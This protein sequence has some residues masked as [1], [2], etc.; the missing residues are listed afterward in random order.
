M[1]ALPNQENIVGRKFPLSLRLPVAF[2]DEGA[3]NKTS[4]ISTNNNSI[5]D[6][7]SSP[8]SRAETIQKLKQSNVSDED[9]YDI[10]IIGAG[11]TGAGVALDAASRGFKTACIDMEDISSG[12]SSRS[13]KL[14]WGGSRYLVQALMSLFSFNIIKDPVNTIRRF[15]ADMKMVIDCHRERKFLLLSQPH[16]TQWLPIAVPL[17]QWIIWPPPFDYYPAAIGPLGLFPLFFIFV[18]TSSH[19]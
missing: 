16:L 1:L 18:S 9:E 10:L 3:T 19:H 8:P 4:L 14:I 15:N 17:K 2:N 11:S 12:T 5:V 6:T 7:S 13:T